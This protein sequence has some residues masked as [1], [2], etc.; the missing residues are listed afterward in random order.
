MTEKYYQLGTYTE[1]QW[2][3]LHA[4]L[5]ADGTATVLYQNSA[6]QKRFY[7]GVRPLSKKLQ[8]KGGLKLNLRK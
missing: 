5:I 4:E 6:I 8:Y 7:P 2:D 3:E 1:A